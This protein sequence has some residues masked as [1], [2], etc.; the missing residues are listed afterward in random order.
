M[1]E[2]VNQPVEIDEEALFK[3]RKARTLLVKDHIFFG[4]LIL[5][6]VPLEVRN[7]PTMYTDGRVMAY[8]PDFVKSLDEEEL[9]TGCAHEGLH[10][11]FLHTLRRGTRDPRKWN[12]ACDFA[13]NG[14]LKEGGFT[15]GKE[16]LYDTKYENMTADEIYEILPDHFSERACGWLVDFPGG[17][18]EPGDGDG[19]GDGSCSH[20]H[21]GPAHGADGKPFKTATV[22][23]VAKATQEA[24]VLLAKA[25]AMA[26]AQ[27]TLPGTLRRMLDDM[28]EPKTTWQDKLR[29]FVERTTRNDYSW[30]RPSRRYIPMGVYLPSLY[31]QELG[32][33]VISI[34]TS[35]SISQTDLNVFASE[36]SCILETVNVQECYIIYCDAKVQHFMHIGN[37]D[38]PLEFKEASALGGGGTD[39]RPPFAWLETNGIQPTCHIYFTDMCCDSFPRTPD[40]PMMWVKWGGWECKQPPFGELIDLKEKV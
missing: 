5:G 31:S 24:K 12:A 18:G 35:G 28:L 10:V 34:D 22:E 1:A 26:K 20:N 11:A 23:E 30:S 27:G 2:N 15:L 40:H 29:R 9:M 16:W 39:F 38:L 36:I 33:L 25:A 8:N 14:I 21:H 7:F 32:C 13:I 19:E 3:V 4:C 37:H 6:L 17:T